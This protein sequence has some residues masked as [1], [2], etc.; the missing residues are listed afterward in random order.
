MRL[1]K[2]HLRVLLLGSALTLALFLAWYFNQEL[3]PALAFAMIFGWA[4]LCDAVFIPLNAWSEKMGREIEQGLAR[5][6]WRRTLAAICVFGG[7]ILIA[8]AGM[9][10]IVHTMVL[11]KL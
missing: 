5:P 1:P 11:G 9:I 3:Y 10:V 7:Y 8:A 2:L 4:T 6:D